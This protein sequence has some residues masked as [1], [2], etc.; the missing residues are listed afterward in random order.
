MP[1][2]SGHSVQLGADG[3][4]RVSK[5]I[6]DVGAGYP[7]ISVTDYYNDLL[8]LLVIVND[9]DVKSVSYR[10]LELLSS[11]FVMHKMYNQ[12]RE[13]AAIKGM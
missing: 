5:T 7:Y 8:R 12:E 11:M 10:R 13:Q 9:G 2:P 1:G 4:F 6:G 3:V